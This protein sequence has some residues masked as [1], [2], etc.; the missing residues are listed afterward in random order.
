MEQLLQLRRF[1]KARPRPPVNKQE[2]CELCGAAL[3]EVHSHVVDIE[4]RRV[5]CACRPCYLLFEHRG[6]AGGKFQSVPERYLQI[7]CREMQ[8]DEW[9]IPVGVVFFLRNSQRDHVTAFYPSPAGATESG[10]SPESWDEMLRTTPELASLEADVEALLVCRRRD[11]T[12]SWIVPI[13]ACYELVGR[14]RRHWRGF[15]GG[16]EAWR[17]IDAFFGALAERQ[18]ES[19]A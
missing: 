3:S 12:E 11:R 1:L 10:L 17:E 15:E 6:A 18:T 9:E 5:M 4:K 13:D 7:P 14:I 8:W 2:A 19:A 16:E